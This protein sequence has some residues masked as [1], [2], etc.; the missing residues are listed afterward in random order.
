MD[1]TVSAILLH[2][3]H[4]VWVVR[5]EESVLAAVSV[6][7][8]KGVGALVVV[9]DGRVAGIVSERDCARRIVLEARAAHETRVADIMTAPVVCVGPGE[10][11]DDCLRL[12]TDKRIRH[13]PVLQSDR[14]VGVVS[15]GDL[16]REVISRQVETIQFL[17]QYIEG[18]PFV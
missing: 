4:D 8:E 2:K 9:A 7:A 12:M 3:G 16:V 13:L 14:L 5:P 18:R 15:I 1:A 10:S 11:V 17:E 6:M